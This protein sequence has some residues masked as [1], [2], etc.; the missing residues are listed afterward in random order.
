MNRFVTG[1][2]IGAGIGLLIAPMRGE[3]MRQML[4]ERFQQLRD[5]LPENAQLNEYVSQVSDRMTQ[6]GSN[7]RNYA[8][9][10]TSVAKDAGSSLGNIA[11]RSAGEVQQTGQD[12]ASTTKRAAQQ[13]QS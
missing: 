10:A 3:E 9:Q 13:A 5:S 8:Q 2:L 11:K 6:A 1:L 12:V 4:S 7:L